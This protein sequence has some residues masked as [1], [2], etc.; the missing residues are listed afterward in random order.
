MYRART[1]ITLAAVVALLLASASHAGDTRVIAR[2]GDLAPS[3]TDSVSQ[4]VATPVVN[5]RGE[6]AFVVSLL[7]DGSFQRERA[8]MLFDG[9]DIHELVRQGFVPISGDGQIQTLAT[10]SLNASGEVALWTEFGGTNSGFTEQGIVKASTSD[11]SV[12][13][14]QG[15]PAPGGTTNRIL[16]D[17]QLDSVLPFDDLGRVT[18]R[19]ERSDF[20][21][22]ITRSD[23]VTQTDLA[24]PGSPTPSGNG[25]YGFSYSLPRALD[26][27]TAI[28]QALNFQGSD[29]IGAN[30]LVVDR[31]GVQTEI[32]RPD[33]ASGPAQAPDGNGTFHA[34]DDSFDVNRL[35]EAAFV[36][37]FDDTLAPGVDAFGVLRGDGT[38]TSFAARAGDA[39]PSGNGTF[40]NGFLIDPPRINDHGDL[41][42]RADFVGTSGGND[43]NH[44]LV[45]HNP[46]AAQ[47]LQE[48]VR[49]GDA[50]PG[51]G[52]FDAITGPRAQ[53]E[54]GV[55]AFE[56]FLRDTTPGEGLQGYFLTDGID[57]V[58][59]VRSQ[60]QIDGVTID[61]PLLGGGFRLHDGSLNEAGQV[62]FQ[63]KGRE[64]G[65]G[66]DGVYLFTPDL[67]FRARSPLIAQGGIQQL[68]EWDAAFD[69]GVLVNPQ[70]RDNW[71]LGLTP[72][73]DHAV[74]IDVPARVVDDPND[75]TV[76]SLTLDDNASVFQQNADFT[77]TEGVLITG[78]GNVNTTYNLR[79]ARTLT[80]DVTL[81]G[82]VN[83]TFPD[84]FTA[85]LRVAGP[86]VVEGTVDNGGFVFATSGA[87]F[88]ES[89]LN[90]T[91]TEALTG[92]VTFDDTF[93]N[94]GLLSVGANA[95]VDVFGDYSGPGTLQ[96]DGTLTF[97]A[98]F[99]PGASP[100][101]VE[102][103]GTGATRFASTA[104]TEMEIG[105]TTQGSFAGDPSAAYDSIHLTDAGTLTLEGALRVS[106]ISPDGIAPVF[107]PSEGDRFVLFDAGDGAL[108]GEFD[109]PLDL[110]DLDGDLDWRVRRTAQAF[111]LQV[112]LASV[113]GPPAS[114][115]LGSLAL[116]GLRRRRL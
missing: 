115:L 7:P 24:S 90:R 65:R 21:R 111:S 22:F 95:T 88:A 6:V 105:G 59:V 102:V 18:I 106:L 32:L 17:G 11:V 114:L 108:L 55:V 29:P 13:F 23:G 43:D 31:G 4:V 77:A 107:A 71:T 73:P 89:F 85:E 47:P 52:V 93:E 57:L 75:T 79:G 48:W 83:P 110:P 14:R 66:V 50:A 82:V 99:F 109:T 9:R 58:K 63:A 19:N 30:A 33:L 44:G 49:E 101:Y 87:R 68:H 15:K 81:D 60:N 103:A 35:G 70:A 64:A 84:L 61:T 2:T 41:V 10:P 36:A 69:D 12:V 42:F 78:R 96:N 40:N 8:A 34:V 94:Q 80:A 97:H 16:H 91:E 51:G 28:F 3:G 53:N 112:V 92:Q 74:F 56:A 62:A 76:R 98:G 1:P 46:G 104:A 116:L 113:P 25:S 5:D 37:S 45:R 100:S 20:S 27:G 38:T 86:G 26:D 67:H 72:G 54:A 39:T